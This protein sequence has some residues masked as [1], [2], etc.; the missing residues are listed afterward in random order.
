MTAAA[1]PEPARRVIAA[2]ALSGLADGIRVTAMP[3]LA[4]ASTGDPFWVSAA[5]VAGQVPWLL[6][7]PT[8]GALADRT[9]RA[10]LLRRATA[11]RVAL[12]TSLAVLTATGTSSI[13][14]VL[15]ASFVLGVGEVL[16]DTV[17]AAF[18]PSLVDDQHLERANGRLVASEIVGNELVGPAVGGMLFAVAAALP[19]FTN[20]GLL[21]VALVVLATVPLVARPTASPGAGA[22]GDGPAAG[23]RSIRSR[24]LL[25]T[26]TW[27]SALLAAVDAAWFAL[28]V[29]I[30]D[31][32]IGLGAAGF[33]LLLALG[34]VGGLA[35]A[36]LGERL[37]PARIRVSAGA[38]TAG[39]GLSL[40]VFAAAPAIVTGGLTVIVTS[41]GFAVWNVAVASARQRATPT[42]LLGRVTATFRTLVVIGGIGGALVGGAVASRT[43]PL[44]VVLAA[45][46][47][48]LTA[49]PFV[50]RGFL[51]RTQ[52]P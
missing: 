31:E 20:A 38:I 19:F 36:A 15:A 2:A 4:A 25:R 6:L 41:G 1:L 51:H 35:G 27:T 24:P 12:L 49:T 50:V 11:A 52:P 7:G 45:G 8:V 43:S 40:V 21:T 44:A 46:L 33:G 9:D 39:M 32:Q 28:L 26:I 5:F 29:L 3:L 37:Q 42:E 23:W 18:L 47:V 14:L 10:R 13:G 22:G 30:A 34:A 17:T 16:S 48:L